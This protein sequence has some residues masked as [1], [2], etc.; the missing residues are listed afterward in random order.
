VFQGAP[1]AGLPPGA[2]GMRAPFPGGGGPGMIRGTNMYI[3][4]WYSEQYHFRTM[5]T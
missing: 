4:D 2:S 3:S 1:R 5:L